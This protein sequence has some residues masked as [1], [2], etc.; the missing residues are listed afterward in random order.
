MLKV[1]FSCEG[2]IIN[3]QIFECV[4]GPDFSV[5]GAPEIQLQARNSLAAYW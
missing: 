3:Q 1:P 5:Y 4:L 2:G